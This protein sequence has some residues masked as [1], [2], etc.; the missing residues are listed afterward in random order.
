[1]IIFMGDNPKEDQKNLEGL[2]C[3]GEKLAGSI[4]VV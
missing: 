4:G 3:S 1:L 2:Q